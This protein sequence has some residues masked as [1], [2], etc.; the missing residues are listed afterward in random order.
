[1]PHDREHLPRHITSRFAIQRR[2]REASNTG[3]KQLHHRCPLAPRD[4]YTKKADNEN[5]RRDCT[6]SSNETQDRRPS[7]SRFPT[8]SLGHRRPSDHAMIAPF[9]PSGHT[10]MDQLGPMPAQHPSKEISRGAEKTTGVGTV[11]DIKS[12]NPRPGH[13]QGPV[14]QSLPFFS[15]FLSFF[16][17]FFLFPLFA[18]VVTGLILGR[19]RD[20][21][22]KGEKRVEEEV[23]VVVNE[24]GLGVGSLYFRVADEY[25]R[26][27]SSTV[28]RGHVGFGRGPAIGTGTGTVPGSSA[29]APNWWAADGD[30]ALRRW[31]EKNPAPPELPTAL[32]VPTEHH[33]RVRDHDA[34]RPAAPAPCAPAAAVAGDVGAG[35]LGQLV[36]PCAAGQDPVGRP[37]RRDPRLAA[38]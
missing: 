25:G 32:T 36:R 31:P 21:I 24:S 12:G 30:A 27:E 33:D 14:E 26:C 10:G 35:C 28:N 16:L 20:A 9:L 38:A 19:R 5:S 22:G 2:L 29:S 6:T 23:V 7:G 18:T 34:P 3:A 37:G 11:L 13:G 17:S 15:S 8:P 4:A 1:M